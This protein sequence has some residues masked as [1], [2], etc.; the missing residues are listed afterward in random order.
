MA[1]TAHGLLPAVLVAFHRSVDSV[2]QGVGL[3]APVDSGVPGV[4][5]GAQGDSE[6]SGEAVSPE[7]E[8]REDSLIE[9]VVVALIPAGTS[10]E[11]VRPS[12]HLVVVEAVAETVDPSVFRQWAR[13]PGNPAI[14]V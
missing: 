14:P 1:A 13:A 4:D 8:D 9:V 6:V 2:A 5:S 12:F 7:V 3:E 10:G 11:A